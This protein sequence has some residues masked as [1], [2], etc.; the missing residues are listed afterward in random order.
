MDGG[1]TFKD[2]EQKRVLLRGLRDEFPVT[3]GVIRATNKPLQK[4]IGLLLIQ[5]ADSSTADKSSTV[6][7]EQKFSVQ[8]SN[9][10]RERYFCQQKGHI[11]FN[12]YKNP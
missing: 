4:A 1:H 8:R 12:C 3:A 11:K 2:A 7:I 5:E 6:K 9:R 10:D